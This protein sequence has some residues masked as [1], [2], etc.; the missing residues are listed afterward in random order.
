MRLQSKCE[1]ILF[2]DLDCASGLIGELVLNSN[3]VLLKAV[4]LS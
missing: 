3:E 4:N 2:F 1:L